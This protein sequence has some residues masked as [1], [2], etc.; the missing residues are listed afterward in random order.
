MSNPEKTWD[1]FAAAVLVANEGQDRYPEGVEFVADEQPW[2]D[3][4]VWRKLTEHRP[5]VVVGERVELLLIPRH[6]SPWDIVRG[7]VRAEVYSRV[8]GQRTPYVLPAVL[9]RHPMRDIRATPK[10]IHAGT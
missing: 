7:R 3:A 9:G 6:R 10:L 5:A 8:H 1:L 4:V 2:T